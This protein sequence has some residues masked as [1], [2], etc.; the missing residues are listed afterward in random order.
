MATRGRTDISVTLVSRGNYFLM[1]PLLFEAGSGILEPRHAVN[2][3]RPLLRP[4][5]RFI[6]A[7]VKSIDLDKRVVYADLVHREPI[8]LVYDQLVLATG[9]V[10]N[11]AVIPGATEHARPFKTLADAI[12]LRNHAIQRFEQADVEM[13]ADKKKRLLSFACIGG[14]FVGVELMGELTVFLRR[15]C[16]AY[17]NIDPSELRFDL[18]EGAERLAPEFDE[19]LT[20]YCTDVLKGRGVTM[21][22]NERVSRVDEGSITLKSGETVRA[23]TILIAT[24]VSPSPLV[25]NLPLKSKSKRGH[26][27]VDATMRSVDRPELWAIGDCASIPDPAGKPY[28]ALAQHALREAKVLAHNLLAAFE[29][30]DLKPFVYKTKGNLAALGHYKGIAKIGPIRLK[31]LLA[32]WIWRTYYLFQM[33]QWSRRV[34]IVIDWTVALFFT[35]DIVQ[36]DVRRAPYDRDDDAEE[37]NVS[38]SKAEHAPA[39]HAEPE[40]AGTG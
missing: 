5:A 33:P 27:T 15:L 11:T 17:P 3:I 2:P 7:E 24:G 9:G 14:G 29:Q 37:S 10:T 35:N 19:T 21:H 16:D 26:V 28:P 13:D 6:E 39:G 4:P 34:R 31:G 30:R 22:L 12:K 32:W 38:R 40:P 1:T 23:E 25:S 18:I 8:E 20:D 36:L